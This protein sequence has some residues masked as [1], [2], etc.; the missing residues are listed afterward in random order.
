MIVNFPSKGDLRR[1]QIRSAFAGAA[2][3]RLTCRWTR[4]ASGRLV[5]RWRPEAGEACL[6]G[7]E[8]PSSRLRFAA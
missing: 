8:P 1:P 2:K 6:Q 5:A 4:D 3:P 7:A